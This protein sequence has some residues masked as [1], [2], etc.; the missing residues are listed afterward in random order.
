[1]MVVHEVAQTTSDDI[2]MNTRKPP[3]D[4]A[5]ARQ[6]VNHALNRAAF[7]RSVLRGGGVPGGALLPQPYG[8]WGL[9]AD[10]VAKLPGM[11]NG[12][13]DKAR[14]RSLLAQA[15]YGPQ[16][17]LHVTVSVRNIDTSVDSGTW[18]VAE[19]RSVGVDAVLETVE[20]AQWYAKLARRDFTLG[21]NQTGVASSDPDALFY[22][23]FACN[24]Q[25]NYTD[26]CNPQV[27]ALIDRVSQEPD[28]AK[29]RSLA[30]E[31][32]R[33]LQTEGARPV[34]GH[35]LNYYM[36]WPYVKGLVPVNS[37]FNYSRMQDVWL[38]R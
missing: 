13:E 35:R 34:L 22:E 3:F 8:P 9:P 19:L 29:R 6:A 37:I 16:H 28:F 18:V 38:D 7:I 26:Y 24:S 12:D 23:H 5:T 2:I 30:W 15:G 32:D 20:S 21:L 1:A 17:P 25:R 36:H 27:E 31:V 11:G 10:E 33:R 4:D 14:A